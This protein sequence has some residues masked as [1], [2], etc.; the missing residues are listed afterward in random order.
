ML[1]TY[2]TPTT[3]F[4]QKV[5]DPLKLYRSISGTMRPAPVPVA[6][7]DPEV[8]WIVAAHELSKLLIPTDRETKSCRPEELAAPRRQR[9]NTSS[10]ENQ[11]VEQAGSGRQ[12][13]D[14]K[15]RVPGYVA[16]ASDDDTVPVR[17]SASSRRQTI[18]DLRTPAPAP[19]AVPKRVTRRSSNVADLQLVL[20]SDAAVMPPPQ[21]PAAIKGRKTRAPLAKAPLPT[22]TAT[23]DRPDPGRA[24]SLPPSL[25]GAT[26]AEVPTESPVVPDSQD[27]DR[28]TSAVKR[29]TLKVGTREEHDRRQR[30]RE[31]A[32]KAEKTE[33]KKK[34]RKIGFPKSKKTNGDGR[35]DTRQQIITDYRNPT[36]TS[37][38]ST[39]PPPAA[40]KF[41][42]PSLTSPAGT[43]SPLQQIGGTQL[44]PLPSG[45]DVVG[46]TQPKVSDEQH[47]SPEEVLSQPSANRIPSASSVDNAALPPLSQ[48]PL[49]PSPAFAARSMSAAG[50]VAASSA[51]PPVPPQNIPQRRELPVWTSTSAIPFS[52]PLTP[53]RNASGHG[54]GVS[55][56]ML[57]RPEHSALD[58][59]SD[60]VEKERDD[61]GIWEIPETPE[62]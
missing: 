17:P 21:P 8:D 45:Q 2:A 23:V 54:N 40:P 34:P 58:G 43:P 25:D 3:S 27:V 1:P 59:E 30:E 38:A 41:G 32:E 12:L 26:T 35:V 52:A 55:V 6:A 60:D 51:Q 47:S 61:G 31:E 22:V 20:S 11:Q 42:S 19:I 36:K 7:P 28:L 15:A 50:S 39:P 18:A 53:K 37:P 49:D 62:L 46:D 56:S 10:A 4:A 48:Q 24:P 16:P 5:V 13:R 44:P 14:R 33:A 29:I 9:E 57:A